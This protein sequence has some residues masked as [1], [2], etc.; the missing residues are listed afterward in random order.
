MLT[1]KFPEI[2][3]SFWNYYFVDTVNFSTP[4]CRYSANSVN[5]TQNKQRKEGLYLHRACYTTTPS[6][7]SRVQI[8]GT[9]AS[10]VGCAVE[11]AFSFS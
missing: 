3:C 8:N 4:S 11:C 9:V 2:Y 10:V 5:Q 6:V 7:V 1:S